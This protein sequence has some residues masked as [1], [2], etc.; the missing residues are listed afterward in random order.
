ME[1]APSLGAAPPASATAPEARGGT[2]PH[3]ADPAASAIDL[4]QGG[5]DCT[6]SPYES[7]VWGWH[8]WPPD[9]LPLMSWHYPNGLVWAIGFCKAKHS[10]QATL[11]QAT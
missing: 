9:R 7:V 1:K 6:L 8:I 5:E 4:K 2:V 3:G 10:V 11:G